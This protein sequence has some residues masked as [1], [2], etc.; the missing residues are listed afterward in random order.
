MCSK[1]HL[2][3]VSYTDIVSCIQSVTLVYIQSIQIRTIKACS[4][5]V[6]HFNLYFRRTEA[7]LLSK[8]VDFS[9]EFSSFH[10]IVSSHRVI[11][12]NYIAKQLQVISPRKIVSTKNNGGDTCSVSWPFR[13]NYTLC[14]GTIACS[15]GLLA[16]R[17]KMSSANTNTPKYSSPI[18]QP[19][20][21]F[22]KILINLSI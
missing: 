6:D 10:I 4:I 19:M 12:L 16:A 7:K 11:T 2:K 9:D 20:L 8:T 15:P 21:D 1:W 22:L 3:N 13:K 18:L 14:F 5:S 17:R